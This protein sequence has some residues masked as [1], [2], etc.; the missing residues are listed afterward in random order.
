MRKVKVKAPAETSHPVTKPSCH[1]TWGI[2]GV[3]CHSG[4]L[5]F[6]LNGSCYENLPWFHTFLLKDVITL[7]A[8]WGR[9]ACWEKESRL[10]ALKCALSLQLAMAKIRMWFETI[11]SHMAS[12]KQAHIKTLSNPSR[13]SHVLIVVAFFLPWYFLLLA[14]VIMKLIIT[15]SFLPLQWHLIIYDL[16]FC[17]KF[18]TIHP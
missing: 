10:T 18:S 11:L 6:R 5:Q 17:L 13:Q 9:G 14:T 8:L 4:G 12:D 15:C 1:Q 2:M 3:L 16:H 7:P